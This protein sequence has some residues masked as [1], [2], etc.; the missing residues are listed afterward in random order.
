MHAF[1]NSGSILIGLQK[2]RWHWLWIVLLTTQ[3][4]VSAQSVSPPQSA[5]TVAEAFIRRALVDRKGYSWLKELSEIGP[6]LS[7]SENSFRAIE[8]ARAR[9]ESLGF[10]RVWLQPVMVPR[11]ERG[12]RETTI[13]YTGDSPG[14]I[15]LSVLALGGSVGTPPE[16]VQAPVI[17]INSFEELKRRAAEVAGKIVFF[18]FRMDA[19]KVYTFAGYGE[20]VRYRVYGAIEAA[21]LGAVGMVMR[22]ITTRYDDVPHTGV[23]FYADTIPRIPAAALG[24]QSANRLEQL[25]NEHPDVQL[26]LKLSCRTLPDTLSYNV[27]GEI[28]GHERPDEI[29][30]VGGHFDSWDV[31]H[32]AHD[33]GAGCIQALE[34]AELFLRLNIRPRRTIRCVFFI[35]EENGMR[36]ARV[37]ARYVEQEGE[38]HY[39]AIESDR[40]AFTPRGFSVT[41]DSVLI[42]AMQAWIPI[43]KK[44]G[45]EWIRQGGSGADV[46]R[47]P[48]CPLKFGFVPDSQRYFDVHHSANDVFE[49]VH[50]RELELGSA[51]MAI[52]TYLLS[53]TDLPVKRPVSTH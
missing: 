3:L 35:N 13:A 24:W 25:L 11:W 12:E 44:A 19:G 4:M 38:F 27:I 30:V 50:P 46:S 31:G 28:R 17:Q 39:A 8:W 9:M 26:Q 40:G 6:R 42:A 48:N 36:G 47:I 14:G 41:A 34:A 53:E 43:L 37:Y 2:R 45:I 49:A 21:K 32:G 10:D 51:A 52:L 18:N 23:M 20:A 5:E 22:S 7:G 16:G 33:D 1:Q 15:P 29:I